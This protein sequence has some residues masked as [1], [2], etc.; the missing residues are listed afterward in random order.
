MF[1]CKRDNCWRKR[2]RLMMVEGPVVEE[3]EDSSGVHQQ[4]PSTVEI[5]WSPLME[6]DEAVC[7]VECLRD[8]RPVSLVAWHCSSSPPDD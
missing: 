5:H 3:R 7:A 6:A 8:P 4:N 2:K 1:G